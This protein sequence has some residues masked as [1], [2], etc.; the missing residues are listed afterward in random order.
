MKHLVVLS[1]NSPR[2]RAWGE[3]CV[4][5]FGSRFDSV[6]M[7]EYDHWARN[8]KDIDVELELAKLAE[9]VKSLKGEV[10]VLAKSIGSL[11]ILLAIQRGTLSPE[12]CVFFGMPL[13]LAAEDL[14]NGDWSALSE[15]STPAIAF[16]NDEDPISYPYTK[17]ALFEHGSGSIELITRKGDNHDYLDFAEYDAKISEFLA[18]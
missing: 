16:H 6:Y 9:A 2:N 7:Q 12:K 13:E 1:G 3:G 11:L 4:A 10:Y 14:F 8:S 15:F 17:N 5:H 18:P